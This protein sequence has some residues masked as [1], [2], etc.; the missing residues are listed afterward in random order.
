MIRGL[1]ARMRDGFKRIQAAFQDSPHH[2]GYAASQEV[3][4][5]TIHQPDT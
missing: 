2:A 5:A 1:I 4:S 3:G